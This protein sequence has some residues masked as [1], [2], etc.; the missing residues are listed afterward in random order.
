MTKRKSSSFD[1]GPSIA[2]ETAE[3]YR[4][5]GVSM[6]GLI[7]EYGLKVRDFVLLSFVCD[8]GPMEIDQLVRALG[9]SKSSTLGFTD[10]LSKRGLIQQRPSTDGSDVLLISA[11]DMGVVLL[12][13]IDSED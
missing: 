3:Q 10:R 9:L 11:T 7:A 6:T 5:I 12:S 2:E 4:L 8:Q 1:L 13:K